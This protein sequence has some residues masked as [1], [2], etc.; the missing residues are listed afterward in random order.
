MA[1]PAQLTDSL[2]K[3]CIVRAVQNVFRTMLNQEPTLAE[4][5]TTYALESLGPPPYVIGSVGF[6]GE[7]NGIVYL[8]LSEAFAK[9]VAG[10]MLGMTPPEVEEGGYEVVKDVIGE[11]TNMTTGGFKNALCDLG[12]PCKL[13]LP[14]IVRGD[15]I[16][17]ASVKAATRH[18]F[19]FPCGIGKHQLIADVQFKE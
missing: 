13:S 1:T 16:A 7:A 19:H 15:H 14:T 2:I 4:S 10:Q 3:E 18:V 17:I 8:C 9:E 11:I 12:Y 6:A 5:S